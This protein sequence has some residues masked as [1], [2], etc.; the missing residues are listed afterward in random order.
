MTEADIR[1]IICD[2]SRAM[3]ANDLR[4]WRAEMGV[5]RGLGHPITQRDAARALGISYSA[6]CQYE[7]D[8]RRGIGTAVV[9]P[10]PVALACAAVLAGLRP[11]GKPIR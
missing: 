1:R 6:Y 10:N 11:Y 5:K 7:L 4:Q 2:L 9:I 3:N 8:L